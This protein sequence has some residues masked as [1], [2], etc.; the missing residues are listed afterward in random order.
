M[1]VVLRNGIIELPPELAEHLIRLGV[2]HEEEYF[3]TQTLRGVPPAT[4]RKQPKRSQG[5]KQPV[6]KSQ[7]TQTTVSKGKGQR[8]AK[9]KSIQKD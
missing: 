6:M 7:S 8:G 1:R 2:A 4:V 9:H 5:S 3:G